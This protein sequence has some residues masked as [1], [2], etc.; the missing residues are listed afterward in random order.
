MATHITEGHHSHTE[1]YCWLYIP[2]C[3]ILF[4][5]CLVIKTTILYIYIYP[6]LNNHIVDETHIYIY[7]YP[8]RKSQLMIYG[9]SYPYK[10]VFYDSWWYSMIQY[11]IWYIYIHTYVYIYIFQYIS[12]FIPTMFFF[13]NKLINGFPIAMPRWASHCWCYHGRPVRPIWWCNQHGGL[14]N[15]S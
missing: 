2:L 4:Q 6:I 9:T 8:V 7:I 14:T 11:M 15:K 10:H 12:Y 13:L 1:S 3:H 5:W